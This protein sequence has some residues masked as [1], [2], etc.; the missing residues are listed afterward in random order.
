MT[1]FIPVGGS[2][3]A[4]AWL[5]K[6]PRESLTVVTRHGLGDNVF[7]SPCFEPLATRFG[8][9]FFSS[10]VNAYASLFHESPWVTPL[11]AGGTNANNLGLVDAPSF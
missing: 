9:V 1:R 4:V 6:E 3:A 2:A 10:S 7:Y 11:Y 5:L 8:K